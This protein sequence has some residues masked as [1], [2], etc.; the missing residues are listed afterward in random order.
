MA[1]IILAE[2]DLSLQK[3]ITFSLQKD[4]HTV[5]AF[6]NGVLAY[7][8]LKQEEF[9]LLLT[10]IVMPEMDGIELSERA[11]KLY[12]SLGVIF[13]TGYAGSIATIQNKSSSAS[14]QIISKPF[15]LGKLTQEI[16]NVLAKKAIK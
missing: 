14:A 10:D 13:I 9:D 1:R 5:M 6:S 12:P 11:I 16:N 3:F 4:G 8:A 7:N 2:D 15:H